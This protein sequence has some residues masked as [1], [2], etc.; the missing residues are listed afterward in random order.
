MTLLVNKHLEKLFQLLV[1]RARFL[2]TAIIVV[3]P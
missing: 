3:T 2:F 1:T